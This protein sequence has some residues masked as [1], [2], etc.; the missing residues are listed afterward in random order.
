M[1]FLARVCRGDAFPLMVGDALGGLECLDGFVPRSVSQGDEKRAYPRGVIG[2]W[3]AGNVPTLGL[4][5]LLSAMITKNVSIV[6][7]PR[8]AENVLSDLL[9]HFHSLGEPHA[10]LAAS[11][12]V[13][14]YDHSDKAVAERFSLMCDTRIIWGGDE[15]T[16]QVKALPSK[17]T[18]LDLIFPD[19]TSFV[20]IGRDYL[21][22]KNAETAAR[23]IA[24]DASVFEQKAC[25]SP[26]TVLVA[27]E[28]DDELMHFCKLLFR[29]MEKVQK[30]IPKLAPSP[31]SASAILNLRSQYD[32]FHEAWYPDGLSFTI[33]SDDTVQL[34]P[35][36]G[37]R[38]LFVR[39]LP[40]EEKLAQIIPS[41]IQSVGV[42]AS[43]QEYE[44]LTQ[45]LGQAG[46]H[47]I[48][49]LGGMTHFSI[50]WDGLFIPQ[51]LVRWTTRQTE[52]L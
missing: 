28:S 2:H 26:H 1:P 10:I 40:K 51:F 22:G 42:A 34:G 37:D 17:R 45:C 12:A 8:A 41:N 50:P 24:H 52:S 21:D 49:R 4:L 33:L 19:R 46:V 43:G 18:C 32:I 23:L 44:R 36:I 13:V 11:V 20:V 14:R 39:K 38:T 27:A 16:A 15:S 9:R 3:I 29:A 47:R 35:P 30:I 25:A 5:S 6:R 31:T 7:L 48:T